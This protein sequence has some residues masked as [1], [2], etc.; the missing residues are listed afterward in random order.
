MWVYYIARASLCARITPRH[1]V[2]AKH[3]QGT[4]NVRYY[5]SFPVDKSPLWRQL[6]Q[7]AFLVVHQHGSYNF[8]SKKYE[9]KYHT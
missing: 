2:P 6:C 9:G 7:G 5:R 8:D 1:P 4:T 3:N